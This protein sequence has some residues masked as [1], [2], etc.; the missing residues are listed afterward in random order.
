[1][2]STNAQAQLPS[3]PRLE[4][5]IMSGLVVQ[6]GAEILGAV[7]VALATMIV[8]AQPGLSWPAELG[9]GRESAHHRRRS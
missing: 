5:D 1:M 4:E 9:P 6:I 7:L 3:G 8:R 2:P